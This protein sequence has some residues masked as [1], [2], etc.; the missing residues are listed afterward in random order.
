MSLVALGKYTVE[1]ANTLFGPTIDLYRIDKDIRNFYEDP[2]LL[3]ARVV[4]I[5]ALAIVCQSYTF[6]TLGIVNLLPSMILIDAVILPSCKG[7]LQG[8]SQR[9]SQSFPSHQAV[10]H[11][12]LGVVAGGGLYYLNRY[13]L[14][15]FTR[16]ME[17]RGFALPGQ[18]IAVGVNASGFAGIFWS[19]SAIVMP[20]LEEVIF[21]GHLLDHAL[22]KGNS[23]PQQGENTSFGK[24]FRT[25]KAVITT[26]V[27]FGLIHGSWSQGWSNVGT[28]VIT[29]LM[30]SVC[31]LLKVTT[32]NLWAPVAAHA[33]N[34]IMAIV[35]L[36]HPDIIPSL[37]GGRIVEILW[38]NKGTLLLL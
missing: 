20:L 18:T 8:F 30:G 4:G 9:V 12:S 35:S 7:D 33:I 3:K 14:S 13:M 15:A 26:S 1:M 16:A 17:S 24:C 27:I 38:R 28:I 6:Y 36:R 22:S 25:M 2:T 10:Q 21:R 11:L 5:H 34:N 19:I 29:S 23:Q 31:G 37:E 32:G